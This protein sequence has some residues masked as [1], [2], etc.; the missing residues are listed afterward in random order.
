VKT[1]FRVF[2]LLAMGLTILNVA[3]PPTSEKCTNSIVALVVL[4]TPWS[5]ALT[6]LAAVVIGLI[7]APAVIFHLNYRFNLGA[8]PEIYATLFIVGL[9]W[10]GVLANVVLLC[11]FAFAQVVPPPRQRRYRPR[12]INYP[13]PQE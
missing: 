9:L 3:C 5:A 1:V 4:S 11:R 8:I 6:F 12:R 2:A 7:S 10:A 13:P